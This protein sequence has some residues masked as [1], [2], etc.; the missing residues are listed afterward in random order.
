MLPSWRSLDLGAE[1]QPRER[2]H[3]PADLIPATVAPVRTAIARTVV[4]YV[5]A[6]LDAHDG[7][8]HGVTALLRPVGPPEAGVGEPRIELPPVEE[9]ESAA[10]H[11][12]DPT[13]PSGTPT[14]N[15]TRGRCGR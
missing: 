10:Q 5:E 15:S 8:G 11:D 7:P 13:W 2:D 1:V 12:V 4:L 3:V 9:I 14:S 6:L